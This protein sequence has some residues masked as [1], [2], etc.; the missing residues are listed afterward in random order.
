[1]DPD[2]KNVHSEVLI[3]RKRP[4]TTDEGPPVRAIRGGFLIRNFPIWD[5]SG[6]DQGPLVS[7]IRSVDR[8]QI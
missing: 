3:V 8:C 2:L 5:A 4:Q 6:Q 7:E 1:M